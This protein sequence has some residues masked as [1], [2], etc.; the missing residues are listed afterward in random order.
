MWVGLVALL[1]LLVPQDDE[2]F[3][4]SR[5]YVATSTGA[6]V[7]YSWGE[8]WQPVGD[9]PSSKIRVFTCLGPQVF[10]GGADGMFF[11]NDYGVNWTRMEGWNGGEVVTILTSSYYGA[12][13]TLFAGTTE[14]LFRSRDAGDQWERL[15]EGII[16]GMVHDLAWPGPSVFAATSEGLFFSEDGGDDW[17]KLEEGLPGGALLSLATSS[18]FPQEPTAFVGSDRAG[19][20]QTHDGGETFTALDGPAGREAKVYSLFWWRASFFAGTDS[21]LFVSHDAGESWSSASTELEGRK[22]Y[23]ILIP[24]P[25]SPVGSDIIVGTDKGVFKSSDGALSWRHLTDGLGEPEILGFG[26]FPIVQWDQQ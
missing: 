9:P 12:E 19:I 16:T 11:S 1:P 22:V 26:S 8:Q 14:G 23:R 18:Y 2:E 7:S 4:L 5:L 13:P 21:G 6:Y 24:A 25:D 15:G 20:F 3:V 10:A 17:V